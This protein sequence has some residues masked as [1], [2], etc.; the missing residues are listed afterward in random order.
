[1]S[2]IGNI[3]FSGFKKAKPASTGNIV[4]P[5]Q[6]VIGALDKYQSRLIQ[7]EENSLKHKRS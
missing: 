7:E 1:M 4:N 2:G 3:G 5:L 6:G